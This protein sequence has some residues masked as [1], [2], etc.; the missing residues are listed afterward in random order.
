MRNLLL[1]ILLAVAGY[2]CKQSVKGKNGVSY[3]SAVDYNDYIVNRQTS[4]MKSV[5]EFGNLPDSKMDSA[6]IF[7]E[8]YTRQAEKMIAEIKGMP[9]YKGDSLLRDAAI[10]SFGFYKRIFENDYR[11]LLE[12]RKK[13][14]GNF[15]EEDI[16]EGN[17]IVDKIGKEEENYD[18]AFREAQENYAKKNKMKLMDNKIQEEINRKD[19]NE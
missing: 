18:R 12:I 10:R 13:G 15:T 3:G 1:F 19:T 8:R 5:L 4:L 14:T 2:S 11:S 16:A 9:P 6:E 17:R 7:L